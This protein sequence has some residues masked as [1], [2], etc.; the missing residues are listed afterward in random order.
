MFIQVGSV[1][2]QR[3]AP[4]GLAALGPVSPPLSMWA[5]IQRV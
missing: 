5:V 2:G 1:V 3:G 4:Q